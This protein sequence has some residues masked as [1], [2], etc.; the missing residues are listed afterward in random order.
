M[1][2]T[3]NR[4]LLKQFLYILP[5]FALIGSIYGMKR[6]HEEPSKPTS[7]MEVEKPPR[8]EKWKN[9]WVKTSDNQIIAMPEWQVDQIK[10]LQLL[11]INQK[12][13]NSKN[14]PI[15]ASRLQKNNGAIV[16]TSTNTL[17]LI[18][19]ALEVSEDPKKL[20]IFLIS[21]KQNNQADYET[22]I[23]TAFDLEANALSAA[24]ASAILSSDVQEKIS[25]HL[26]AP[27]IEYFTNSLAIEFISPEVPQ[28]ARPLAVTPVTKISPN[29]QYLLLNDR[30]NHHKSL[31]CDLSAEQII[32]PINS[33]INNI[34]FSSAGTYIMVHIDNRRYTVYDYISRITAFDV[35]NSNRITFSPDDKYCLYNNLN[36]PGIINIKSHKNTADWIDLPALQGHTAQV[37]TIQFSPNGQYIVSGSNDDYPNNLILWDATNFQKITNLSYEGPW[38]AHIDHVIQAHFTPDNKYIISTDSGKYTI[39]WDVASKKPIAKLDI[40]GR[41]LWQVN[42]PKPIPLGYSI[43]YFAY[44]P[45]DLHTYIT[46][47][48]TGKTLWEFAA[49]FLFNHAIFAINE[50]AIGVLQTEPQDQKIICKQY[51]PMPPFKFKKNVKAILNGGYDLQYAIESSD[52]QYIMLAC[53]PG[54]ITVVFNNSPKSLF[55]PVKPYATIKFSPKNDYIIAT[56]LP[57]NDFLFTIW[58]MTDLI[59]MRDVPYTPITLSQSRFLYRL[60]IAHTN[61]VKIVID[62]NDPD[63]EVYISLPDNIKNLVDRFLPFHIASDIAQ[64][65]LQEFRQ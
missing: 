14:N 35:Y 49:N 64:K 60:Y 20:L 33:S 41:T 21:T 19:T 52:S 8:V 56:H 50:N 13:T 23:N 46:S 5:L 7:S 39:V 37:N 29:G 59:M 65:A 63:Y 1:K 22:L 12:G 30:Y 9:I 58:K 18:K 34:Q 17:N 53:Y 43:P 2:R 47:S 26:L 31:L 45:E 27:I 55:I 54:Y 15:D 10:V 16:D 38:A 42:N 11:L 48:P 24:L 44:I 32:R 36:T 25:L 51:Y 4:R 3:S 62:K 61:N 28:N 6:L 40:H 57:T